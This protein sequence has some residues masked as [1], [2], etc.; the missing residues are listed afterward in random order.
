MA[1]R[2]EK[3]IGA[4]I[5]SLGAQG[6]EDQRLARDQLSFPITEGFIDLGDVANAIDAALTSP[7]APPSGEG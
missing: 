6:W 1:D 7:S 5:A 3:I 4:I 2:R